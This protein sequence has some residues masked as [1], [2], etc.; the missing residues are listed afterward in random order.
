[1]IPNH[2]I[3]MIYKETFDD[4]TKEIIE[5]NSQKLIDALLN[6]DED[7]A[8]KILNYILL[9]SISYY[10]NKESFYHGFMIGLMNGNNTYSNIETGD[11]RSDIKYLPLN[12]EKRGFI[13]DLKFSMILLLK[14]AIR[15]L[16]NDIWKVKK[17]VDIRI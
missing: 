6:K 8:N 10:D 1:M 5:N 7:E 4:W 14:A 16:K 17:F 12:K 11:G 15:L 9:Q 2:E 13:L 3:R